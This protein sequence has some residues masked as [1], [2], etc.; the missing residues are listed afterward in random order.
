MVGKSFSHQNVVA[1]LPPPPIILAGQPP[2]PSTSN[3][4][5]PPLF[6]LHHQTIIARLP[7]SPSTA[8]PHSKSQNASTSAFNSRLTETVLVDHYTRDFTREFDLS[9]AGISSPVHRLQGEHLFTGSLSA[10]RLLHRSCEL[11]SPLF[12][13]ISLLLKVLWKL[14]A[15]IKLQQAV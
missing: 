9:P 12:D 14:D 7:L 13:K 8:A 1:D 15:I 10:N 4:S 11:P 5:S 2:S 3:N 6:S